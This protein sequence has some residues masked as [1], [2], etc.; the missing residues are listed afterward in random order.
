MFRG[1]IFAVVATLALS[2]SF[3]QAEDGGGGGG[4]MIS[5][6]AYFWNSTQNDGTTKTTYTNNIYDGKVGYLTSVGIYLGGIYTSR[7]DNN[8]GTNQRG[9]SG[10]GSLGFFTTHG[11]Y[12]M[13]H[14]IAT[15]D[16]G[17][18]SEGKGYQA[19]FGCI[20]H[21]IG[22]IFAGGEINYRSITYQKDSADATKTNTVINE[23]RPMVTLGLML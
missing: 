18:F 23:F 10:G 8:G 5:E 3:A 1:L 6:S 7:N 22:P 21:L 14:Y 12:L 2:A 17:N 20:L 15:A 9:S 13:G 16:Y 4:V 11:F 19:D